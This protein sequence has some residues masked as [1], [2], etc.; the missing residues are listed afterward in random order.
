MRTLDLLQCFEEPVGSQSPQIECRVKLTAGFR[1]YLS[2]CRN[3]VAGLQIDGLFRNSFGFEV[4][5]RFT[6]RSGFNQR[7]NVVD[8]PFETVVGNRD[9]INQATL[10]FDGCNS[11]LSTD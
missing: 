10:S 7:S 3:A 5:L 6:V 9:V 8:Q 4:L 2:R 11:L 1:N